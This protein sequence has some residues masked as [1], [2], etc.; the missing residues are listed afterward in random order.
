[1]ATKKTK[2]QETIDIPEADENGRGAS[3]QELATIDHKLNHML[4]GVLEKSRF[5]L[6]MQSPPAHAIRKRPDGFD[7]LPHGYVTHT[8]NEIFGFDWDHILLPCFNGNNH[9]ILS[10]EESKLPTKNQSVIVFGQLVIRIWSFKNGV[11]DKILTTITKTGFG[12]AEI[13]KKQEP[14]D[15]LK[16][17]Q[18]D[19]RKVCAA[20]LGPRLG[21]TLYY[22]D[23][24]EIDKLEEREERKRKEQAESERV[25]DEMIDKAKELFAQGQPAKWI[26]KATGLTMDDL[27]KAGLL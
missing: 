12:S 8:L 24:A 16:G 22:D 20:Q 27:A 3:T 1:M 18:S 7:Y 10:E 13:R 9:R 26:I 15:A 4:R 17:A 14:G 19:S 25:T 2:V 11:P 5:D 6:L 23:E 21:L